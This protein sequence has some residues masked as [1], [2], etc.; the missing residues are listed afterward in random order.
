MI[1]R[2][3]KLGHVTVSDHEFVVDDVSTRTWDQDLIREHV[4]VYVGAFRE[5]KSLSIYVGG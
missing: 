3:P 1:P 4:L 5:D 2:D